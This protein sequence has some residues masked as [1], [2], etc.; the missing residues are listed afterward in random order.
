MGLT[1]VMRC[2]GF[3]RADGGESRADGGE[4]YAS[5]WTTVIGASLRWLPAYLDAKGATGRTTVRCAPAYN[6]SKTRQRGTC[7]WA[8][9]DS[10]VSQRSEAVARVGR[11]VRG[12]AAG[13]HTHVP[14]TCLR[15]ARRRAAAWCAGSCAVGF[16]GAARV[17]SRS[18]RACAALAMGAKR[19][20]VLAARVSV[21]GWPAG[22][23]PTAAGGA[24][25]GDGDTVPMAGRVSVL[26]VVRRWAY[27]DAHGRTCV[28]RRVLVM[29]GVGWRLAIGDGAVPVAGED[30]P[31]K[32]WTYTG[33]SARWLERRLHSHLSR[34]T[35]SSLSARG[36][37]TASPP[38][39][40][41]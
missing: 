26:E 2:A 23:R 13:F 37:W 27:S 32:G 39:V 4:G 19:G 40:R 12:G 6:A 14:Y 17:S 29:A 35:I 22:M 24:R 38:A 3:R 9:G 21:V 31:A 20:E 7:D 8:S 36:H 1:I 25:I 34:R 11:E 28:Q 16:R 5:G 30:V 15:G 33:S 41:L 10:C 18:T